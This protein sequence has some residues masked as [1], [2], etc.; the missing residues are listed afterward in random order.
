MVRRFVRPHCK[1]LTVRFSSC[2]SLVKVELLVAGAAK[3]EMCVVISFLHA[4][5]QPAIEII[6]NSLKIQNKMP[7]PFWIWIGLNCIFSICNTS[8]VD[9]REE[10]TEKWLG[11]PSDWSLKIQNGMQTLPPPS[12]SMN[13]VELY[14]YPLRHLRSGVQEEKTEK[15]LSRSVS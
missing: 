11:I 12:L 13:W 5:G 4:E 1:N 2:F 8:E 15:G 10:K 9:F 14:F 7:P 3:F 6:S